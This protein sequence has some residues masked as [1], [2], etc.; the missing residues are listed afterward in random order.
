M[1]ARPI[2]ILLL[3]CWVNFALAAEGIP[4]AEGETS[5]IA[6]SITVIGFAKLKTDGG[7]K[8]EFTWHGVRVA[9]MADRRCVK[10]TRTDFK[11]V[12]NAQGELPT[13]VERKA[14]VACPESNS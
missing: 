13:F 7:L 8:N 4:L 10:T 12:P 11:F 5:V 9:K 2:L 14:E 6:E 3:A 1:N